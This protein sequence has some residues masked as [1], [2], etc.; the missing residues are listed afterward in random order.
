MKWIILIALLGMLGPLT[1]VLR[2]QPKYILHAC[3]FMGLLVFFI[4]PYLNISPVSWRWTG[5]VKGFEVSILDII[6]FAIIFATRPVRIPLGLK[7]GVGIYLTAMAISTMMAVQLTPALFS[8]WQLLRAILVFVAV[9]RATAVV[10]DAPLALVAGLG[11]GIGIESVLATKQYLGGNMQPGGTLGHRNILGLTSHFAV[12][13]AFALLLAGRRTQLA[14]LVVL[15]G[16][17]IAIAGGGRATIGLYAVG[18]LITIVL[19]IR[20][21]MTGRKGA[22]AGAAVLGLLLAA[23]IMLWAVERRS[24]AAR[25]SSD[26]ERREMIMAARMI[27]ADNPMGVGPNQYLLV[28]NIGGYSSRAGVAWNTANRSAPVHN[29]YYLVTAEEGFLGLIGMIT[30]LLSAIA[31]GF[32]ALKRIPTGERSEIL[33]GLVAAMMIS[34][35]HLAFEWVFATYYVQYLLA[36]SMGSLVGITAFLRRR[37]SV[38]D[39]TRAVATPPNFVSQPS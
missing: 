15:A 31:V 4:D 23:P 30:T 19:S 36:M 38:G 37:Q 29:S 26:E 11:I 35:V 17:V 9:A 39:Q 16:A 6:A 12:M 8:V 21:K 25:A 27:I 28:A 10:K 22:I 20:H 3:F 2:S 18:L 34:C 32:R 24:D 1:V 13:P 5:A 7:V 14:A 33:V